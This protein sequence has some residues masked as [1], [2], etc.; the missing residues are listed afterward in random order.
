MSTKEA[1][2]E[3]ED[4]LL[5]SKGSIEKIRV[6]LKVVGEE[7]QQLLALR[8][9]LNKIKRIREEQTKKDEQINKLQEQINL[10]EYEKATA[11][12]QNTELHQIM[13]ERIDT[14]ERH[15]LEKETSERIHSERLVALEREVYEKATLEEEILVE[16]KK[17]KEALTQVDKY[18]DEVKRLKSKSN[19]DN[20]LNDHFQTLFENLRDEINTKDSIISDLK[21]RIDVKEDEFHQ[22]IVAFKDRT[23]KLR[24]ELD[25]LKENLLRSERMNA[26]LSEELNRRTK[27]NDGLQKLVQ[28]TEQ[29]MN[30]FKATTQHEMTQLRS[31][32]KSVLSENE[33]LHETETA[34]H[35]LCQAVTKQL[36]IFTSLFRD[37]P[38]KFELRHLQ[39]IFTELKR[40]KQS[41]TGPE[42][43]EDQWAP[44]LTSLY[45]L[46]QLVCE[47]RNTSLDRIKSL[48]GKVSSVDTVATAFHVVEEKFSSVWEDAIVA[49]SIIQG[50]LEEITQADL[51]WKIP[52]SEQVDDASREDTILSLPKTANKMHWNNK[53]IS[54]FN[55]KRREKDYYELIQY[56]RQMLRTSKDYFAREELFNYL[57]QCQQ[58]LKELQERYHTDVGNLQ[59]MSDE[60]YMAV[61]VN[62]VE[63]E[64]QLDEIKQDCE[65]KWQLQTMSLRQEQT[66]LMFAVKNLQDG[67]L[68]VLTYVGTMLYLWE[69]HNYRHRHLVSSYH[70]AQGLL[71][72]YERLAKNVHEIAGVFE[73]PEHPSPRSSTRKRTP[74]TFRS[75]AIAVVVMIHWKKLTQS[76][77]VQRKQLILSSSSPN[78]DVTLS[79]TVAKASSLNQSIVQ[80][81]AQSLNQLRRSVVAVNNAQSAPADA[82]SSSSL[83]DD[84]CSTAQKLMFS[85]S[86]WGLLNHQVVAT[87][88]GA[89]LLHQ[90]LQR[91][92]A[93][94]EQ[95][96]QQ[97]KQ[98]SLAKTSK[99]AS[100]HAMQAAQQSHASLLRSLAKPMSFTSRLSASVNDMSFLS[101]RVTAHVLTR[102]LFCHTEIAQIHAKANEW[103]SQLQQLSKKLTSVM[104]TRQ[105]EQ[106]I[107]EQ[108]QQQ[109]Q[110]V[111]TQR[112]SAELRRNFEVELETVKKN[113]YAKGKEDERQRQS[114]MIAKLEDE[115]TTLEQCV[116]EMKEERNRLKLKLQK[117][118]DILRSTASHA[119]QDMR[120]S[121]E[122]L[123]VNTA[124][125]KEAA[126]VAA[127]I[128]SKDRSFTSVGSTSF[129]FTATTGSASPPQQKQQQQGLR[130]SHSFS[131][132]VSVSS[133][134]S[135][136]ARFQPM[137]S[138]IISNN[139][140]QTPLSSNNRYNRYLAPE[141]R[142]HTPMT[143]TSSVSS[144][145]YLNTTDH[146][147]TD[148]TP[149]SPMEPVHPHI[150]YSIKETQGR[151][152]NYNALEH[153]DAPPSQQHQH[154]HPA[155]HP[156]KGHDVSPDMHHWTTSALWQDTSFL[157]DPS[158]SAV[159]S[160]K[161]VSNGIQQ[162]PS[163]LSLDQSFSAQS[164]DVS[165][166][167]N[168]SMQS[169]SDL[170]LLRLRSE[171]YSSRPT[172]SGTVN[173]RASSQHSSLS[174]T[175]PFRSHTNDS[176]EQQQQQQQQQQT[177]PLSKTQPI[178]VSNDTLLGYTPEVHDV[179]ARAA[180][181]RKQWVDAQR[182]AQ[183]HSDRELQE[184][185]QDIGRMT[186]KLETRLSQ[187]STSASN[188]PAPDVKTRSTS[189]G[190]RS[191]LSERYQFNSHK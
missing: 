121:S 90:L 7:E 78:D 174:M 187:S 111:V 31:D 158:M 43:K 116:T 155:L 11:L 140:K 64:K 99:Y 101:A 82:A 100:Y 165:T 3:I 72:G 20:Q 91:L 87:S 105:A 110:D 56:V 89:I 88:D 83:S 166:G 153:A 35:E 59:R 52:H 13:L 44:L 8:H 144:P 49:D 108:Q 1:M 94:T 53:K 118:H 103:R 66:N 163:K 67:L 71:R 29:V 40:L 98:Q 186:A 125:E 139:T 6:G 14:L 27:E 102:E 189:V 2:D 9:Q 137:S 180:Q 96:Q 150:P 148:H 75:A 85:L 147:P 22:E 10:L 34:N 160:E 159:L 128:D 133:S 33:V 188:S 143:S 151:D 136:M 119:L 113:S 112:I 74:V 124:E 81:F 19:T 15:L 54:K 25:T 127:N 149:I 63:S 84:L 176:S 36:T 97:H 93:R 69:Q 4:F 130:R 57:Q 181:S 123:T 76:S 32:V 109:Q 183:S 106:A 142:H 115:V 48:E 73:D 134:Q 50:L 129:A 117:T 146:T 65:R 167:G 55:A 21:Q 120:W 164:E 18:R 80:S 95:Q 46:I 24:V 5:N 170:S 131:G 152:H 182:R 17:S 39:E 161:L 12:R 45:K 51:P 114:S 145:V 126:E 177:T 173:A 184:I 79:P 175:Y 141:Q 41:V 179:A 77:K 68:S 47:K 61:K 86:D 107:I 185:F 104:A 169:D 138:A 172:A 70:H 122:E 58:E 37:H 162:V 191:S 157:S 132:G 38:E 92:Q 30:T 60:A 42:P 154:H 156:V 135:T 168:Q 62:V 26:N 16:R 23:D 190:S 28:E 178:D 171:L